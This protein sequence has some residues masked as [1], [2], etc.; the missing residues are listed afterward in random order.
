MNFGIDKLT[1]TTKNF[2]VHGSNLLESQ[3]NT[4]AGKLPEV[5]WKRY[6]NE[7]GL[8][9][10]TIEEPKGL[11]VIFNPSK[12]YGTLQEKLINYLEPDMGR[13]RTATEI[14]FSHLEQAGITADYNQMKVSRIDITQDTTTEH[15]TE[16]YFP[17]LETK[18]AH[19]VLPWQQPTANL[20]LR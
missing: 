12:I 18:R 9:S 6:Y 10:V 15:E 19:H 3:Y 11:Q 20:H 7:P 17:A 2:H 8:L 1:L 13:I 14:V 4:K 5:P 16:T